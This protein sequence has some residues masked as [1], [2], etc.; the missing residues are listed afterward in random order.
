MAF[1]GRRIM[2][3]DALIIRDVL[4]WRTIDIDQLGGHREH[5]WTLPTGSSLPGT[6]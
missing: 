6:C 5:C 1:A 4:A 2:L 3:P